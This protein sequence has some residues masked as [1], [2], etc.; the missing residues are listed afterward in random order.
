MRTIR[1]QLLIGLLC[2]TLVCTGIAGVAMYLTLRDEANELF[3]YQLKQVAASL[4]E[5]LSSPSNQPETREPEEQVVIQ[6][7]DSNGKEIYTSHPASSL[8]RFPEAGF[9]TVTTR[10]DQ[11]R[12]Y[13]EL[14]HDRFVQVAQPTSVRQQLAA[15]LVLRSLIPFLILIPM[16]AA[17]IG[18][19]VRRS[20]LPLHQVAQ[21]VARRSPN[22]LHP[23]PTD[24]LPPEVRPMLDSLNDLL[25]QLDHALSAQRAF[26]ADAAHE[27]RSP[28][29]ALKL[30]LQ[31]AERAKTE[32]QRAAAFAKLDERLDRSTRLVQQLLTLARHEQQIDDQEIQEV[33]LYA[34][35][36][37]IVA[38]HSTLAESKAIDLG[39]E[40]VGRT[41]SIRGQVDGLRVMMNNLVDNAV[42]YTPE[43]GRVDVVVLLVDGHPALRIIDTGPGIPV[44]DRLRVFDRFY[45]REGSHSS[46]SGVGLSIVKHI[47]NQ[48]GATIDLSE[49]TASKGLVVTVIF[50]LTAEPHRHTIGGVLRTKVRE[51]AAASI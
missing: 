9:K 25:G 6:A 16:L 49:N 24:G 48:H 46:G 38:D 4:P 3:D 41:P 17:L 47:A 39:V 43:G 33:D 20:L 8:M 30:Q 22:A 5:Q 21:A 36:Q 44:E 26:V 7:W 2:G 14:N 13:S 1:Q 29:T 37:R 15:G 19:V 12:I 34:L 23:L 50:P 10:N 35:A 11:W 40:A 27:L 42:R 31:L 18:V 51:G 45:R 32:E 28:L